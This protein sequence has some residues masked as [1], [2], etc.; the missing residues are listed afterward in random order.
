M[1]LAIAAF[2]DDIPFNVDSLTDA[3]RDDSLLIF[4]IMTA[5]TGNQQPLQRSRLFCRHRRADCQPLKYECR[6]G[7]SEHHSHE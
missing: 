6:H 7:D 3:F 1:F 2:V 4:V 5:A